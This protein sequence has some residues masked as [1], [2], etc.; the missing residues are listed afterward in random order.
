M[1]TA[2]RQLALPFEEQPLW[3]ATA[4]ESALAR[5]AGRPLRLT[6]TENRSVLLSFRRQR[7]LTLV[8]LHRM[9]LHAPPSV[10][11]AVARSLRRTRRRAEADVRRFMNENLHRVRKVKRELPPLVTAGQAHDLQRVFVRLN[12]RFFDSS[13]KVPLTWGKGGGRAR[14]G[15]LTFGSYDPVLAL[16][17][18][19]WTGATCPTTSWR[20]SSTTRCCTTTWAA[21]RTRRG[22]RSTTRARSARRKHA[23]RS[24]RRPWPGRKR[25]FRCCCGPARSWTRNAAP[26]DA[27]AS[28]PAPAPPRRLLMRHL[29]RLLPYLA[30]HRSTLVRGTACLLATTAL[31]VASPWVLRYAVDDLVLAVTRSKLALYA[32]LTVALVAVEGVFRYAMRKLLIGV[33][34]EV[35]FELRSDVFA[36]LLRLEARYYQE[37]RV[38]DLMSRAMSD[39]QAVR[40][41]LGPGIMYTAS[42]LATFVGTIALM[43][44]ISP[45][46][47]LLSL[48]PLLLVSVLVRY[49]G[50]RIHDRFEAVQAQLSAMTALVQENLSGARVVRAYAQEPAEM[51]RFAEVNEEYVRRNRRLVRMYGALYPGIQL[52]MGTGTV[53]VLWLG[54]QQVVS[55]AITLGEFV[56]F[57]AYLTMLHWPMIALGWVVNIFERGEASMGRIAAVLDR[58]PAINDREA[59]DVP[60]LRGEV[61]FRG[62]T[63]AYEPD[64]PVLRDIDLRVPAGHTVAIVGATGSG[65][66]TLVSLLPRL[67]DPPPG[68]V[69]VDGVDVR[70]I[71]L[72]RL[73]DAVG[74]VPQ[75]TFLFS[76]TVGENVA[77]GIVS[78]GLP[79]E[80]VQRRSE[81][82]ARTAQLAKDVA[83]FPRGYD[84]LVGERG[85]TLS[86]GQKQRTA[87]ARALATDP[88]I[89][90]LDDALSA[91]DTY[92]EEEVLRGLR[93]ARRTRTTFLVSHRVSTV[94]DADVILVLQEG[95]VVEQGRHDEL[96]ARG[97]YYADLHRR[98]LLQEQM[99]KTA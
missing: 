46:L 11:A 45:R 74:F 34:R 96:V 50:R 79:P 8:R 22:A 20:A 49:F 89:L 43:A 47:L 40:M 69:F 55:G 36:H 51:A 85:I 4:L 14:R 48:L 60:P 92:T 52:L 16:S 54:G 31:S 10:V 13:L 26:P 41:V 35:E 44:R 99:E 58:A 39:L 5:A 73:R 23:T 1:A 83:D 97:G 86:G 91:V 78:D 76:E 42:T 21:S 37:H 24:T 28:R 9:F 82:A 81:A 32:S 12:A 18:R 66:S 25:T 87:L 19:C 6:L 98:Q 94:K 72:A 88:R 90:I 56:A 3:N 95:R 17:T 75:E 77:F 27:R 67:Y 38:G 93:E 64:R 63:F 2:P 30:R 29:R 33:S 53:V 80:D 57:G 61:E 70:E 62:L 7:A 15:G 71:P 84:T 59:R 65:K 68:T